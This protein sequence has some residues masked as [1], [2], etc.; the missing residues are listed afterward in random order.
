MTSKKLYL[1]LGLHK[2]GTTAFQYAAYESRSIL[3]ENGISYREY[4]YNQP[5]A[6]HAE[7]RYTS[8]H[9]EVIYNIYSNQRNEYHWNRWFGLEDIGSA[10]ADF[11]R[12]MEEEL[13]QSLSILWSGEDI[14]DLEAREL[15]SLIGD[16]E[17]HG[18]DIL[19]FAFVRD[20]FHVLA[21][22]I[23]EDISRGVYNDNIGLF[24]PSPASLIVQ[25]NSQSPANKLLKLR[26]VFGEKLKVYSY[27]KIIGVSPDIRSYIFSE[28]LG[29]PIVSNLKLTSLSANPR[30][31]NLAVRL[32]NFFNCQYIDDLVHRR[33]QIW[34]A[35]ALRYSPPFSLTEHEYTLYSESLRFEYESLSSL[36][37]ELFN[38]SSQYYFADYIREEELVD[39]FGELGH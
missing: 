20:P 28:V 18:F 24:M 8:N 30:R 22:S 15:I 35:K 26:N 19:P 34:S 21:A 11:R 3:L 16:V 25:Q 2:T 23:Q 7:T 37:G 9:S 17:K 14:A 6:I 12:Q 39:A 4:S 5:V 29:V 38:S 31:S 1:H 33:P 32:Q 27:D 10:A 13:D 36:V